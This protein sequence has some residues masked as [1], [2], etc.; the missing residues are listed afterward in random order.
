MSFH[1]LIPFNSSS[2][3]SFKAHGCFLPALF[4]TYIF[5]L[6]S[7]NYQACYVLLMPNCFSVLVQVITCYA[8]MHFELC[9]SYQ[10]ALDHVIWLCPQCFSVAPFFPRKPVLLPLLS[11]PPLLLAS[12]LP[13]YPPTC[14]CPRL[15]SQNTFKSLREFKIEYWKYLFASVSTSLNLK[16]SKAGKMTWSPS[17]NCRPQFPV[18]SKGRVG[19]AS[20]G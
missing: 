6:S 11:H 20:V 13:H 4:P 2:L 14:K 5:S 15:D 18:G 9:L 3:S 8:S 10:N 17:N 1:C 19:G 16:C 7:W 12:C